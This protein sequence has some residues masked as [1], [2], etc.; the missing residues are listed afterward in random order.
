MSDPQNNVIPAPKSALSAQTLANAAT[1][2]AGVMRG[3]AGKNV[4]ASING[5]SLMSESVAQMA[6]SRITQQLHSRC[7]AAKRAGLAGFQ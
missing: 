6:C 2:V 4:A 3:I 7:N 5:Q 1:I